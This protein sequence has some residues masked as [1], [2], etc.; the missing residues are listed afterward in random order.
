MAATFWVLSSR[1]IRMLWTRASAVCST[2]NIFFEFVSS[3]ASL[4]K[5]SVKIVNR[6]K[7]F[8]RFLLFLGVA[9]AELHSLVESS[10]LSSY[11][12][13]TQNYHP[14]PRISHHK[15]LWCEIR[16]AGYIAGFLY[17]LDRS[18]K[19]LHGLVSSLYFGKIRVHFLRI[20]FSLA[21]K[22]AVISSGQ[23]PSISE[24]SYAKLS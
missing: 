7:S 11:T 9:L 24:S 16:G 1:S 12:H 3:S 22:W 6:S 14:A 15:F 13:P 4:A 2:I 18:A 8:C 21:A 19:S 5:T 10:S 23:I 17:H 20:D